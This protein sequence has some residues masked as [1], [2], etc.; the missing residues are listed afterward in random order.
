[1]P[2]ST[3]VPD[4]NEET[5]AFAAVGAGGGV[6]TAG[7]LISVLARPFLGLPRA[8]IYEVVGSSTS[9]NFDV[10]IY[11]DSL[12]TQ[13][14]RIIQVPAIN[15]HSVTRFVGGAQYNDRAVNPILTPNTQAQ[16]YVRVVN[17]A[18]APAAI[19]VRIKYLTYVCG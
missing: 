13:L 16:F 2:V 15:L 18:G 4:L 14:N 5:Q 10:E 3:F 9:A 6:A 12:Y 17:N 8:R 1:M 11:E 7:V 19:T